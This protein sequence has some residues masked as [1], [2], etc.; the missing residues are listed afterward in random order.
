M[1]TMTVVRLSS[2]QMNALQES[3]LIGST[4]TRPSYLEGENTLWWPTPA[5]IIYKQAISVKFAQKYNN[6]PTK[7]ERTKVFDSLVMELYHLSKTIYK[8]INQREREVDAWEKW[9]LEF[10]LHWSEKG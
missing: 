6:I 4:R 10:L 8:K 1:M 7:E 9:T 2:M 5:T 3:V